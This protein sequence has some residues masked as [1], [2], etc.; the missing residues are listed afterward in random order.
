MPEQSQRCQPSLPTHSSP[1]TARAAPKALR[2]QISGAGWEGGS[3]WKGAPEEHPGLTGTGRALEVED[4]LQVVGLVELQVERVLPLWEPRAGVRWQL[5]DQPPPAAT[6]S[7]AHTT[8]L[9]LA[10]GTHSAHCPMVQVSSPWW[11]TAELQGEPEDE[12]EGFD[13]IS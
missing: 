4:G 3:C 12:E 2:A 5:L 9:A 6:L 1:S 8:Q 7:P 10:P 13:H 11:D